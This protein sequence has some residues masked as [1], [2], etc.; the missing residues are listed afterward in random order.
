[1]AVI[2]AKAVTGDAHC[3]D[4]ID[5]MNGV[6]SAKK[7]QLKIRKGRITEGPGETTPIE[8]VIPTTVE[9]ENVA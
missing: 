4:F 3:E 5:R 1:M 2:T 6:I 8:V 9:V 7:V